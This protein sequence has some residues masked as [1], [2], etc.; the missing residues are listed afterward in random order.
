[1]LA[2]K[3]KAYWQLT[4]MGPPDWNLIIVVA[5]LMGASDCR[6]WST[7]S[8]GLRGVCVGCRVNALGGVCDQRF[9]RSQG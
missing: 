9:C 5:N 3:A 2:T 6:Q 8:V 4:R 7:G 1:M